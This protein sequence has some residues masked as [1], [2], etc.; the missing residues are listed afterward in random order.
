MSEPQ[1]PSFE[2]AL[3]RLEEIVSALDGEPLE[4]EKALALFEEGIARLRDASGALARAEAG[5][6][7]LTETADGALELDDLGA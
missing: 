3:A 2:A 7:R 1:A 4:L 5:L 6:K